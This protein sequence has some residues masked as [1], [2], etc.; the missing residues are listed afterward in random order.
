AQGDSWQPWV[1]AGGFTTPNKSVDASSYQD[2]VAQKAAQ[3][4]TEAEPVRFDADDLMPAEVQQA[5]FGG[6]IDYVQN[7]D[8]LDEILQEIESTAADAYGAQ[9]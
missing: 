5:F 6:I 1:E 4:L 8:Q 2:P 9:Q 7:P 3:Q